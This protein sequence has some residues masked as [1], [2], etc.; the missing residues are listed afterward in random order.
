MHPHPI[1]Q[2]HITARM[3]FIQ[4][5]TPRCDQRS[6]EPVHCGRLHGPA[7]D[8]LDLTGPIHPEF[9]LSGPHVHEEIPQRRIVEHGKQATQRAPRREREG[10]GARRWQ[11]SADA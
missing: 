9:A 3:Q 7:R 10:G 2:P 6:S 8:V 5:P 11:R 1:S 4:V